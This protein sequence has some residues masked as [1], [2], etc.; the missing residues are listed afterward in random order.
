MCSYIGKLNRARDFQMIFSPVVEQFIG[1]DST[2]K[3][4]DL[5]LADLWTPKGGFFIIFTK[6]RAENSNLVKNV[7]LEVHFS[8]ILHP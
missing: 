1:L 3:G 8:Q 7:L 2:H 5:G 6:K 4:R